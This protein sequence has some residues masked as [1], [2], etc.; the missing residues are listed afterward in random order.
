MILIVLMTVSVLVLVFLGSNLAGYSMGFSQAEAAYKKGD[1]VAAYQCLRGLK[2][3]ESDEKFYD[4]IRLTAYL[5]QELNTFDGYMVQEAYP[6]ALD[7]LISV[8]GKYDKYQPEAKAVNAEEEYEAL[9]ALAAAGLEE[10][11]DVS[12]EE[13]REA[14]ALEDRQAY[15]WMVYQLLSRAGVEEEP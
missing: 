8:V 6:E 1:Y 15:T 14:Y 3:K 11:F 4:K 12:V 13:A 10:V 2:I 7:A 9:L 5:Q